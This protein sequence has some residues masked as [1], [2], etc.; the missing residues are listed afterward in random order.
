MFER[1]ERN[2][3]NDREVDADER[4]WG[5]EDEW[6]G[7]DEPVPAI[8]TQIDLRIPVDSALC[9]FLFLY[10]YHYYFTIPISTS[11][12]LRSSS[13]QRSALHRSTT[14]S[15]HTRRGLNPSRSQ[16]QAQVC[17][18]SCSQ[19]LNLFPFDR[20]LPLTPIYPSLASSF[21]L[22]CSLFLLRP[23]RRTRKKIAT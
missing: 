6:F 14:L 9:H 19:P 2:D 16:S 1:V 12:S 10:N 11:S 23:T 5:R 15:A 18:V 3:R 4:A 22:Q 13:A 20:C 21:N 7:R 17:L 8:I